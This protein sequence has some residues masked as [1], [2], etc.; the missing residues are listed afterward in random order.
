MRDK[1]AVEQNLGFAREMQCSAAGRDIKRSRQTAVWTASAIVTSYQ[2][3]A[4]WHFL[5]ISHDDTTFLWRW[6]RFPVTVRGLPL[7]DLLLRLSI[8]LLV[9]PFNSLS[10]QKS[11]CDCLFSDMQDADLK[12]ENCL[13][14]TIDFSTNCYR[15]VFEASSDHRY[16]EYIFVCSPEGPDFDSRPA[17]CPEG[18]TLFPHFMQVD[19]FKPSTVSFRIF[20]N[21]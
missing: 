8:S 3:P 7:I 16:V 15:T 19:Y 13:V 21:S 9:F 11:P 1:L 5:F 4:W 2:Y 17:D 14:W 10:N 6:S 18:V 12:G 20:P